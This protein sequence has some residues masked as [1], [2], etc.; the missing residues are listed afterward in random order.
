M[1]CAVFWLGVCAHIVFR[2]NDCCDSKDKGGDKGVQTLERAR[3]P[4]GVDPFVP[5][6]GATSNGETEII[7]PTYPNTKCQC[8]REVRPFLVSNI[9]SLGANRFFVPLPIFPLTV[10]GQLDIPKG[11]RR[12]WIDVGAHA[13]CLTFE[14]RVHMK[15]A[16][17]LKSLRGRDV[18]ILAFEPQLF[19]FGELATINLDGWVIIVIVIILNFC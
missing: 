12:I 13:R 5:L 4:V 16:D 8:D 15:V 18:L 10:S 17:Y 2:S 3:L 6:S 7:L 19:Q 1:L 14:K 11:V 9:S